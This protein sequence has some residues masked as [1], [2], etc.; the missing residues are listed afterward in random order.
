MATTIPF[1][2]VD[3]LQDLFPVE[4]EFPSTNPGLQ[5]EKSFTLSNDDIEK[6]KAS[7]AKE[8]Q[9][10]REYNKRR[11]IESPEVHQAM[12]KRKREQM[13]SYRSSLTPEQFAIHRARQTKNQKNYE[14]KKLANIGFRSDYLAKV[15]R[16]RQDEKHGTMTLEDKQ[17]LALIRS[18]LARKNQ[19]YTPRK[20]VKTTSKKASSA[21]DGNQNG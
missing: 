15:Q 3:I 6:L 21:S 18:K 2:F 7:R 4:N 5:H 20:R 19:K 8:S 16:L 14:A 12:L 1:K 11:K 9:R 13:Q 10:K 17:E